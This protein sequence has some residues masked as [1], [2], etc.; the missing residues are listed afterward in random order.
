MHEQ[1]L[2]HIWMNVVLLSVWISEIASLWVRDLVIVCR[3]VKKV[4]DHGLSRIS[5]LNRVTLDGAMDKSKAGM[6]VPVVSPTQK[7]N[8][9]SQMGR[10]L[11]MMLSKIVLF[12][13]TTFVSLLHWIFYHIEICSNNSNSKSK[14]LNQLEWF[15]QPFGRLLTPRAIKFV[16][17]TANG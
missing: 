14:K 3:S 9:H 1:G 4:S 5:L 6:C 2:N 8:V 16:D 15:S 11:S 10:R 12:T 17:I 13:H 7:H